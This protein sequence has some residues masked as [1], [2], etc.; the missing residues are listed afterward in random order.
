MVIS[1]FRIRRAHQEPWGYR[2]AML[3]RYLLVV[4]AVTF[5]AGLSV[6]AAA[7]PSYTPAPGK[8]CQPVGS[9]LAHEGKQ[10]T[11]VKRGGK[12]V[13]SKSVPIKEGLKC[14][15]SGVTASVGS[16]VYTCQKNGKKRV[17]KLKQGGSSGDQSSSPSGSPSG[18]ET[19]APPWDRAYAAAKRAGIRPSSVQWQFQ[20]AVFDSDSNLPKYVDVDIAETPEG[21]LRLYMVEFRTGRI[22][23]AI[24]NNGGRSFALESG[25][26][27]IR[28][29]TFPSV[30]RLPDGRYRMYYQSIDKRGVESGISTDGGRTFTPEPGIR[31]A[32]GNSSEPAATLLPDGRTLLAVK[33]LVPGQYVDATGQAQCNNNISF[34]NLWVS[35][36]G[37][38][39]TDLGRVVDPRDEVQRGR[40]YGV[41]FRWTPQGELFMSYEG[42]V[43]T[44]WSPINLQSLT[45]GKP[46]I[47]TTEQTRSAF[48]KTYGDVSQW[49]F[50]TDA[51]YIVYRGQSLAFFAIPTD[52]LPIPDPIRQRVGW[53]ILR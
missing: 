11:C 20:P 36:D 46:V 33:T 47:G 43:M 32:S 28:E 7:A 4:A 40:A 5:S 34:I 30:V 12:L 23:S 21:N 51:S 1:T 2:A 49:T 35:S 45:L 53:A 41:S 39:F 29:T 52:A 10:Y 37:L 26:T 13:W 25:D 18:V 24:S 27:G 42:C 50:P 22:V 16:A 17:W 14:P 38:T 31:A 9:L 8:P 6:P 48:A 44:L 19:E 3:W 15:T